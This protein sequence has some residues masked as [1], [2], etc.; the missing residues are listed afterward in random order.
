MAVTFEEAGGGRRLQCQRAP[1]LWAEFVLDHALGVDLV[2][3]SLSHHRNINPCDAWPRQIIIYLRLYA[4]WLLSTFVKMADAVRGNKWTFLE[5][6]IDLQQWLIF[7]L[8]RKSHDRIPIFWAFVFGDGSSPTPIAVFLWTVRANLW[9]NLAVVPPFF[10]EL[11]IADRKSRRH[12]VLFSS[13]SIYI[14]FVWTRLRM[15]TMLPLQPLRFSFK[16]F[17]KVMNQLGSSSAI[18]LFFFLNLESL[19]EKAGGIL[20]YFRLILFIFFSFNQST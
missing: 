7:L 17:A 11:G 12:F 20:F 3:F 16:P 5:W 9:L 14:F 18:F 15:E 13:R 4:S 6:S 1:N 10:F 19:T 8:F 2:V